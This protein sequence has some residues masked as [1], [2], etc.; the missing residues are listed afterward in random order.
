MNNRNLFLTVL[1]DGKS[2]I[3]GPAD[4]VSSEVPFLVHEQLSFCC[5]CPHMM[6]TAGEHS[7]IPFIR[8]LIP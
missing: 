4:S 2:K 1:E 5:M 8:T 6:N 3:K 7:T